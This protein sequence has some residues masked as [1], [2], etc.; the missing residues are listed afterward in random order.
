MLRELPLI[1]IPAVRYIRLWRMSL[2][3]GLVS[4]RF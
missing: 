4:Q 2:P 1:A 3:S